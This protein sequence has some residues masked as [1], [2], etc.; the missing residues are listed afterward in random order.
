MIKVLS[1]TLLVTFFLFCSCQDILECIINKRPELSD[2]KLAV[3]YVNQ[4]YS[5]KITADIKNEP[6]DNS[7]NY[8]FH[9]DGELPDGI[10]YI[11][12]YRS[13]IL[14]GRP[15]VSGNY[16]FTVRLSAEQKYNYSEDCESNYN[17]CDGLCNEA[18]SKTY[19]IIVN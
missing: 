15:L 1:R 12:D 3:A 7:Y 6:L 5:E 13:I 14:E 10:E 11:I 4:L 2:R 16:K 8:Y 9:I 18:T 17:D 19:T